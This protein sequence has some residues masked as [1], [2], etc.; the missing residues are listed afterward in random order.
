[1]GVEKDIN[2]AKELYKLAAKTDKNAE[3]LLKEVE[4]ADTS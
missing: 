4:E 3:I 1:M 2:R